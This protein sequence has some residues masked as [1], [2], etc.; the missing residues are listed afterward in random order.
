MTRGRVP[1]DRS[2]HLVGWA[3]VVIGLSIAVVHGPVLKARAVS[4]DDVSFVAN[5]RLVTNPSWDSAH[6][7]F[8]E[9]LHPSTVPGYYLPVS[10]TSLMLDH[11][12]GG[13]T[14]QP[15]IFHRTS[16]ALHLVTT[17]LIFLFLWRL[18]GSA[19][20]A[21]LAALAFGLH[22]LTV[23]PV[24]WISERKTLLAA[25]FGVAS[26]IAYVE[27]TRRRIH[28]WLAASVALFV[29]A[30]MSKPS[31]T[32]LPFLLLLL[33]LW[34]L[35]RLRFGT[36]VEK[37]PYYLVAGVS[38]VISV[39][40]L[41]NTDVIM[42]VPLSA[43]GWALRIG[44]LPVFYL[45]KALW[46]A[47]LSVVYAPP[48]PFSLSN[49]AVLIS[50]LVAGALSAGLFAA[51]KRLPGA[52]V[53]WLFMLLALAPT[54]G[55][56]AWSRTIAWDR[57]FYLPALGPVLALGWGL[58]VLWERPSRSR[59]FAIAACALLVSV[60]EARATRIALRPWTD[61]VTLWRNA[62]A[63]APGEPTA[64]NGLGM[65]YGRQ[66]S[67]EAAAGE[68]RRALDAD[69][70]F[71]SSQINLGTALIFLGR[72]DEANPYLRRAEVLAPSNPDVPYKL[73]LAAH[74]A[75]KG[76]SAAAHYERALGL[77][78]DH[79]ESLVEL[80]ILRA[81]QGRTAESLE[82][83]RRAATLAPAHVGARLGLAMALLK[84]GGHDA[85]AIEGFRQVLRL[86]PDWPALM[87][88]LAWLLATHPDARLRDGE[89]ALRLANR[90]VELT[91]EREADTFDTRAAAEAATGRFDQAR[92]SATKALELAV[93]AGEDSLA[94]RIR[95]RMGRYERGL[96]YTEPVRATF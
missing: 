76:D 59:R 13:R 15:R 75:G 27:Y 94:A 56:L 28:A 46:P 26:M 18:F 90:V 86:K 82:W 84:T 31:V 53:G 41:T 45:G 10:M 52:W 88:T 11:A 65:A 21:G 60:A 30:L 78:P 4:A 92:A 57:Y 80:G 37:W 14:D 29:L 3:A 33:D 93:A 96:I 74:K 17:L 54:F 49:P 22:P 77:R 73:G 95:L 1:G 20:P 25:L 67:Y 69:A 43:L 89:E 8:A 64:H 81:E 34:P 50:C 83:M 23:E 40:S 91:S 61:S 12:W 6:R 24:A 48:D 7:F 85:E 62:V 55:V 47:N 5:N 16:L 66:S 19:I 51:R 68:F 38:G 58:T 36:V 39:L 79:V 2:W 44:Y 32:S 42:R 72:L 87:N 35:K 63:I 71:V 9:V 70:G